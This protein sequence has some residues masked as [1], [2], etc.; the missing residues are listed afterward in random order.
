MRIETSRLYL[1]ELRRTDTTDLM[2]VLSD[3]ESMRYYP[4]PFS[5]AKVLRWIE[6]NLN[7]YQLFQ[8]GLWA[9]IRK[10]DDCFLGDCGIT[11]QEIE[12]LSLPEIG[13]HIRKEYCNQGYATEAAQACLTDCRQRFSYPAIYSYSLAENYASQKVAE[14]LGMCFFKQYKEERATYHVYQQLF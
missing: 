1:R 2:K 6:W 10:E 7:N 3:E 8:H 5:E 9:V 12:G 13:F 11:L 14:K 4:Q